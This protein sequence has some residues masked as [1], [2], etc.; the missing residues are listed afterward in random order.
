[1]LGGVLQVATDVFA[2]GNDA[3]GGG[4]PFLEH[5]LEALAADALPVTFE[6]AD[7][8]LNLWLSLV[9]ELVVK[10]DED[11]AELAHQVGIYMNCSHSTGLFSF[12]H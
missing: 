9:V 1:M 7:V 5:L 8:V 6:A 10:L 2:L 11:L 4:A 3:A 12:G